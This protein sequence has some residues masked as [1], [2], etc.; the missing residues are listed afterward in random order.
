MESKGRDTLCD[1]FTECNKVLGLMITEAFKQEATRLF[2]GRRDRSQAKNGPWAILS[3][4]EQPAC[5][6]STDGESSFILNMPWLHHWESCLGCVPLPVR[7]LSQGVE[8]VAREFHP[9]FG[10]SLK[11]SGSN[12]KIF[13]HKLLTASCWTSLAFCRFQCAS[14]KWFDLMKWFEIKANL[15]PIMF[16]ATCFL[17]STIFKIWANSWS[18]TLAISKGVLRNIIPSCPSAIPN[19]TIM[20]LYKLDALSFVSTPSSCTIIS[21]ISNLS[22]RRG[23]LL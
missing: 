9:V 1:A 10:G 5:P 22:L 21:G 16:Q 12:T 15:N 23:E 7:P 11:W 14:C 6:V 2:Q 3:S 17:A 4:P 18:L 20:K 19:F 13:D 8:A